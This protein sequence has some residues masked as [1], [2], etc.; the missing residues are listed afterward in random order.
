[1]GDNTD[2]YDTIGGSLS[3]TRTRGVRGLADALSG[4]ETGASRAAQPARANRRIRQSARHTQRRMLRP[5]DMPPRPTGSADDDIHGA[6]LGRSG[7]GIGADPRKMYF[8]RVAGV[9]SEE[10]RQEIQHRALGAVM[11]GID[12]RETPFEGMMRLVVFHIAG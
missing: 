7:E 12:H 1:M 9:L 10:A 8:Q 11:A 6:S 4:G 2:G 3:Q 5:R